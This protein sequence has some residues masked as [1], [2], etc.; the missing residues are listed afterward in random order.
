MVYKRGCAN[1]II[2]KK[3]KKMESKLITVSGVT[4]Y[5]DENGVAQLSIEHVS[6]GLGF[7]DNSK[8][9]EYVRWNTVNTYLKEIGFS[10]EVAKDDFIPENIFYRLAFKASN[11][12]AE[13]FQAKVADEILPT[14]R[15]TGTYST[16]PMSQ[17]EML[18]AQA[19]AM[20]ELE[21]KVSEAKEIATQTQAAVTSA[22]D[23]FTKPSANDWQGDMNNRVRALCIE[24]GLSYLVMWGELFREVDKRGRV[25]IKGRQSRR[26]SK[27]KSAGMKITEIKSVSELSIVA[28]DPKL[29]EIMNSVVREYEAKYASDKFSRQAAN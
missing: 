25:D 3:M 10:Q 9:V 19:Q 22:L 6:R 4:G 23:V 5:I 14:I 7:T 24:N 29:R 13:L 2:L 11:K 16:K 26:R 17:I 20:V 28:D 12:T 21:H 15:K 8:G 1:K 18:A 27:M